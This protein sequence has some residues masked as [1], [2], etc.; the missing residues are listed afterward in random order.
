[1]CPIA[2]KRPSKGEGYGREKGYKFEALFKAKYGVD[3]RELEG[4]K[5]FVEKHDEKF[6][7]CLWKS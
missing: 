1:V 5:A 3:P 2:D 4:I 7:A 6:E